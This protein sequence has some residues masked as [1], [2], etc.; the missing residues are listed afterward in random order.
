MP[1][2]GLADD[3][4]LDHD[5][6]AGVDV[7]SFDGALDQHV[8]ADAHRHAGTDIA[9]HAQRAVE[10][11]VARMQVD[12]LHLHHRADGD[13]MHAGHWCAGDHGNQQAGVVGIGG[14]AGEALGKGRIV[15]RIGGNGLAEHVHAV[16]AGHGRDAAHQRRAGA[17][18]QQ[19][20]EV[21]QVDA[22]I[23]FIGL[24]RLARLQQVDEARRLALARRHAGGDGAQLAAAFR[25]RGVERQRLDR[26]HH[27][28]LGDGAADLVLRDR[29]AAFGGHQREPHGQAVAGEI[30]LERAI[31]QYTDGGVDL[32]LGAL[33]LLQEPRDRACVQ[34]GAAPAM[35]VQAL[36][37]AGVIRCQPARL[38]CV[39]CMHLLAWLGQLQAQTRL[40]RHESPDCFCRAACRSV[41]AA[42]PRWQTTQCPDG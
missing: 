28:A 7:G 11:D 20:A 10:S 29:A 12:C 9:R 33:A 5:I 8:A 18:Q 38:R 37:Q 27:A 15:H 17:D 4:A 25:Q 14:G 31:D 40:V 22:R 13:A 26:R 19:V 16:M 34:P 30:E 39:A 6:A 1:A 32:M 3:A 41:A 23:F 2:L 36:L 24:H 21:A 42:R 35:A